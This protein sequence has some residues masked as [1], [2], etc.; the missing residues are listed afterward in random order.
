MDTITSPVKYENHPHTACCAH[1]YKASVMFKM[2]NT[3]RGRLIE[4]EAT[5]RPISKTWPEQTVCLQH[6]I[7]ER[8]EPFNITQGRQLESGNIPA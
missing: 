3:I 5:T 6:F 4:R 8:N 7:N 2:P 1:K